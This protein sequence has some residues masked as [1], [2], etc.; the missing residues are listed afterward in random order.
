MFGSV[1]DNESNRFRPSGLLSKVAVTIEQDPSAPI[2]VYLSNASGE[3]FFLSSEVVTV[4]GLEV[5]VLSDTFIG[6]EERR[7]NSFGISCYT[8]GI[9]SLYIDDVWIWSIRTNPSDSNIDFNLKEY[10]TVI[11]KI[12]VKFRAREGS[13]VRSV[14]AFV[15]GNDVTI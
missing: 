10:L 7:I 13:P 8:E 15:Q 5:I 12:E 14:N 4:A 11:S 1:K 2:P 3:H 9:A 6:L